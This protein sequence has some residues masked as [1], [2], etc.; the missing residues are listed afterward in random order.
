MLCPLEGA[1]RHRDLE[2]IRIT[3]QGILVLGENLHG[4]DH[5]QGNLSGCTLIAGGRHWMKCLKEKFH[6]IIRH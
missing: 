1:G 5:I 2:K 6:N 4:P 3:D